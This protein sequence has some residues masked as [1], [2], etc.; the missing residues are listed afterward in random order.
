[1]RFMSAQLLYVLC[2]PA[3]NSN[4]H[5]YTLVDGDLHISSRILQ[6]RVES[7]RMQVK[8]MAEEIDNMWVP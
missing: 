3:D 2:P 5:V 8:L 4:G 7:L 1:M 6:D